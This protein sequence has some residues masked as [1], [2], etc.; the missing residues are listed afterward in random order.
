MNFDRRPLWYVCV[1][2]GEPVGPV[3][4]HQIARAIVR[5]K[6]PRDASVARQGD[7]AWQELLDTPDIVFA[8]KG[9][10]PS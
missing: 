6:V 8:L 1:V 4:A 3:S 5:G 7:V 2:D 9:L 10:G